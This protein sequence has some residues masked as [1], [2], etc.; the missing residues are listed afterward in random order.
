ML[1]ENL[2]YLQEDR[3]LGANNFMFYCIACKCQSGVEALR[4]FDPTKKLGKCEG[5]L[6]HMLHSLLPIWGNK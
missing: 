1:C 6:N 2:E 4:L 5:V 3:C